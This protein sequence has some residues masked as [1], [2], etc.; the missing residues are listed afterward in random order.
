MCTLQ[1][2]MFTV[3]NYIMNLNCGC[4]K[5]VFSSM[6]WYVSCLLNLYGS[7]ATG[8]YVISIESAKLQNLIVELVFFFLGVAINKALPVSTQSFASFAYKIK[9]YRG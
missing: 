8:I 4:Q 1:M 2:K 3:I 7:F 9:H 5:V 6:I